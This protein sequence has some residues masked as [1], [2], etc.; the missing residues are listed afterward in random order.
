[1]TQGYVK[2]AMLVLLPWITC[3]GIVPGLKS[4]RREPSCCA[5]ISLWLANGYSK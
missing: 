3:C 2:N 1:M 4:P 5:A